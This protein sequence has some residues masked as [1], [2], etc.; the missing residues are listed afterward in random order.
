MVLN[1]L[2]LALR[3]LARNP[4]LT[5]INIAGLSVGLATFMMLWPLAEFELSS[6]KYHKDADRIIQ[7]GVD[8]RWTD[9]NKNWNGFLGA[10]N[11]IGVL[12]ETEEMLQQVESTCWI[13]PQNFFASHING[14][15]HELFVS[16]ISTDDRRVSFRERNAVIASANIFDFFT[17]PL[18]KGNR[19]NLLSNPNAVVVSQS[20][21]TKYFGDQDATGKTIYV[22]DTIPLQ[23][24]GVFEDLPHNT[25]HNFNIVFSSAGYEDVNEKQFFK[26]YSYCYLKLKKGATIES[27]N[28]EFARYQNSLYDFVKLGCSH[29]DIKGYTQRLTD[30]V[31]SKLREG[32]YN[33]KSKF[34]LEALAIVAFIVLGFAWINY[35][36]LSVNALN[37]RLNEIGTRKSVGAK[38]NDFLFQFLIESLLMNVI[39]FGIALTLV[40]LMSKLAGDWFKFYI[41]SWDEISLKTSVI[42]LS[43]LGVGIAVAT[44]CPLLLIIRR[45]PTELFR[46]YRTDIK[47]GRFNSVLVTVQ[48]SI[49]TILLVW[50]GAVYFQLNFIL[51]KDLGITKEGLIVVDGPLSMSNVNIGKVSALFT[52]AKRIPGVHDATQSNSTMGGSDLAGSIDV[53]LRGSSTWFG[54]DTNGGVDESFLNTYNIKLVAGR[55]FLPDNP[56]DHKSVLISAATARR[57]GFSSPDEAIGQNIFVTRTPARFEASIIGVFKDYEFRPFFSDMTE[58]DRGVVLTYKGYAIPEFK[59]QRLTFKVDLEKAKEIII[60][61]E[62]IYKSVYQEDMKWEFLDQKIRMQYG[63]EQATRNQLA[64]FSVLA[65]GIT[66]LGLLGMISNKV[67]E[68][69]KE[70]GIRKVLGARMDQIAALLLNTTIR[71]VLVANLVG[72]PLAYYLVQQ[73]LLKFSERLEMTWWHYT[74]PA[75]LLLIIMFLTI[76]SALYKTAKSNPVEALKYE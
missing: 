20:I 64:F 7:L 36:S 16:V 13:I 41:P 45:K 30:V 27:L 51:N 24:T 25:H 35:I 58:K 59:P 32:N 29:C 76:T 66:C 65:V 11:W 42:T 10:F 38:G 54:S 17:I 33:Y 56:T 19:S 63:D 75:L 72:I 31:F 15:D 3:I 52:E 49:A 70:I 14:T 18:V 8:Y 26:W 57:L 1:Y 71:Q 22:N 48:Y 62:D 74:V 28:E 40:Q 37:K 55:N 2:K 61:L 46:K 6:D 23:V 67:M 69:T 43:T 53:Q 34:L 12:H 50:I 4:F 47:P 9:D 21:A 39:A 44:A 60:R 73:Y 68:K 5:F